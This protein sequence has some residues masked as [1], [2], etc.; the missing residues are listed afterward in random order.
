MVTG[1]EFAEE[2]P[3]ADGCTSGSR[4][5]ISTPDTILSER[6]R[7]PTTNKTVASSQVSAVWTL[8]CDV[9]HF[10]LIQ[11]NN[12]VVCTLKPVMHTSTKES[13]SHRW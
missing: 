5:S 7:S 10:Y 12:G 8:P 1:S 9:P 11:I 3:W 13:S 2:G 4:T 6:I